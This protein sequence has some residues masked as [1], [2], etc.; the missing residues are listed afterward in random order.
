M[1]EIKLTKKQWIILK[2]R[3]VIKKLHRMISNLLMY[4]TKRL[5]KILEV[6]S[7]DLI[8]NLYFKLFFYVSFFFFYSNTF[9]FCIFFYSLF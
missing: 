4:T 2:M 6:F 5:T 3:K 8:I 1:Q 9:R 7:R